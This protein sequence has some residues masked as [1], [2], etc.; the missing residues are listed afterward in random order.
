M[1]HYATNRKN[2][3]MTDAYILINCTFYRKM[4]HNQNQNQIQQAAEFLRWK[5]SRSVIRL[6]S[7]GDLSS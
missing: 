1:K 6:L 4:A 3:I 2:N 7:S 5:S